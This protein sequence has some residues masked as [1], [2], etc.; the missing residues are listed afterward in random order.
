MSRTIIIADIH[1]RSTEQDKLDLFCR[2]CQKEA[3]KA[4]NLFILGDLFNTWIGD[5]ISLS[6]HRS[7][8]DCLKELA[9]SIDVF[10]MVGNRDF[11]LG[12][13]FEKQSGCQIISEPY[14]LHQNEKKYVLLHGDSLCTDDIDYQ[15]MKKI[16]RNR[17]VKSIILHLPK[18][19]RLKLSGNIRKKSIQ[20]Q[21]NKPDY[22]MDVNQETT[23]SLMSNY[24][25]A[26][27]IHGH[28][29][30]KN[31]HPSKA[32]T[33]YVL[34]DWSNTQGNAIVLDKTLERLEIR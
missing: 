4:D 3:L 26:D 28:T 31:T 12:K 9:K 27:L 25:N 13:E 33:R 11:L 19:W 21:I 6:E 8:I 14:F 23:K 34:G 20:A 16:L 15:K 2:F 22:I 30:R 24:A 10:I 1:L 5:D 29:H 7:V 17:L 18:K 32:F